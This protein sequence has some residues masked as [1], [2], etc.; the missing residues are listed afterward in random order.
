MLG[1]KRGERRVRRRATG[2]AGAGSI[3]QLCRS[4]TGLEEE[5]RKRGHTPGLL[6]SCPTAAVLETAVV[7]ADVAAPAPAPA[8]A[9]AL[10]FAASRVF[11]PVELATR[12][13]FPLAWCVL[14]FPFFS[15]GLGVSDLVSSWAA[16][17][18]FGA[19]TGCVRG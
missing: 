5:K 16:R 7:A 17:D 9:P 3:S 6:A 10:L 1:G 4:A 19:M 8:P 2:A 11:V 12:R 18:A 13:S 14:V 15:L